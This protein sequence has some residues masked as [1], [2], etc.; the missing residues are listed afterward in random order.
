M[1]TYDF[2]VGILVGIV[3]ACVS[4]VVQSS[5]ISAIRS[6]LPGGL[7]NSTVRRHP[8][9]Q[10]YLQEVGKQIYVMKLAG[11]LFFGTIVGVE[12]RVRALLKEDAFDSH[13]I[14]FLV[15]DLSNVD[16]V[17][18]S[19]AE[20]FTRINRILKVREVRMIMCGFPW[21]GEIGDSL[22]NVGL[23]SE[24]DNVEFLETLNSA[25]EFCENELLKAYYQR[26]DAMNAGHSSSKHLGSPTP[27]SR[28]TIRQPLTDFPEIPHQPPSSS[29]PTE[30]MFSSP[31]RDHLH[32]VAT[33]TLRKEQDSLP[34]RS[35][36][37]LPQPLQLILQTF[38]PISTKDESFWAQ[39]IPF[40]TR[41]TFPAGS[42]LYRRGDPPT[43]FYLLESGI[44]KA[45][46]KLPQG[47]FSELIVAGTTCGELPFFSE[48]ERTAT[49]IVERDCVLWVLGVEQWRLVKERVPE[50]GMELLRLALR[51]TRERVEVVTK[52]MLLS[53]A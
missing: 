12:N 7:A 10:N 21:H 30:T 42:I 29:V 5:Q 50:V 8:V 16:G 52:Y 47:T 3:L 43:G 26:R 31:R 48:T 9:Q 17:D 14:R 51:L 28:T 40:F 27:P 23:F 25:L 1:G 24:D 15:L 38:S 6:V 33:M 32:S 53:S 49:T 11:Y 46:Y 39:T 36:A 44:L 13:P 22:Y 19:A 20:A 35:W 34:H 18:F 4:F 37:Q 41:Q 2:V 45:E